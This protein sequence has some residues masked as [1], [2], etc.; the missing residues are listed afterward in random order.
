MPA[1]GLY[2]QHQRQDGVCCNPP[3]TETSSSSVELQEHIP[4]RQQFL[5][6]QGREQITVVERQ[7]YERL[8]LGAQE[9]AWD[10]WQE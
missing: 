9:G 1:F 6:L 10:T 3:S 7:E 4:Q 8:T 5:G 2:D